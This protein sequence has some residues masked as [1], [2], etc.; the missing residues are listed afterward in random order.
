M[1]VCVVVATESRHENMGIYFLYKTL[2]LGIVLQLLLG[3]E[4][5]RRVY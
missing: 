4:M 5:M 1:R 2:S 3:N